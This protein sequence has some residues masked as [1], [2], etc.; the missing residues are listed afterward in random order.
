M[1]EPNHDKVIA[2]IQYFADFLNQRALEKEAW[3]IAMK[4]T[5]INGETRA[6]IYAYSEIMIEYHKTFSEILYKE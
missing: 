3:I 4:D 5:E 6:E 1:S 2:K